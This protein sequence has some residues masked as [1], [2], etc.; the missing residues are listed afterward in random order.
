MIP[1]RINPRQMNQMMKRLGIKVKEI[2]NVK[3]V[4]IKTDKKESSQL[5][6]IES[7]PSSHQPTSVQFKKE[8]KL[9][10]VRKGTNKPT[11]TIDIEIA[12]TSLERQQGLMYR[13]TMPDSI[14]MLFIFEKAELRSFWISSRDCK[15]K[16]ETFPMM[17]ISGCSM[18]DPL[19]AN[20]NESWA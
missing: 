3:K 15:G 1:G 9:T 2:E 4:I 7:T 19:T 5:R 14:G 18:G 6:S 13:T 17:G 20:L 11:K 16:A 8:G 10:F 12:K